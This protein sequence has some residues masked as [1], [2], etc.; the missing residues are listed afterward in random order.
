MVIIIKQF[1][2]FNVACRV[3]QEQQDLQE[4]VATMEQADERCTHTYIVILYIH[5][6]M[7]V[8]THTHS[9][10]IN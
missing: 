8:Y 9:Q 2:F 7:C 6:R 3:L 10:P 4:L 5:V 1:V